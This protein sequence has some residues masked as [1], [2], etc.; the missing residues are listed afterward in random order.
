MTRPST[1]TLTLRVTEREDPLPGTAAWIL[2]VI[3]RGQLI[4][5]PNKR[6]EP[7]V[8]LTYGDGKIE[9]LA[10]YE[11]DYQNRPRF[12]RFPLED[13]YMDGDDR[14][15]FG[16]TLTAAGQAV[17]KQLARKA[18]TLLKYRLRK[19][20]RAGTSRMKLVVTA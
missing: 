3:R 14:C 12:D 15:A 20:D 11:R 18:Q 10:I 17:L 8:W 16:V 9:L 1:V 5:G 6:N 7:C 19:G 2:D 4:V 13:A